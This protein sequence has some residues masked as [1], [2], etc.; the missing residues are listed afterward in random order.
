MVRKYQAIIF[1]LIASI[2]V[3]LISNDAT[4]VTGRVCSV[5]SFQRRC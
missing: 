1:I 3:C 5:F 4:L 2:A